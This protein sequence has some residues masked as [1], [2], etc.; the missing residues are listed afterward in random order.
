MRESPET[1]S[2]RETT[3]GVGAGHVRIEFEGRGL[4]EASASVVSRDRQLLS[5]THHLNMRLRI[6]AATLALLGA[7]F[8]TLGAQSSF[9]PGAEAN[10][11]INVQILA[12]LDDGIGGYRE[13][14]R[15]PLRL[16]RP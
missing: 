8:P 14:S 6:I 11:Q 1:R 12:T 9:V 16:P 10:G 3:A 7:A 15:S 13:M 5:P 2:R 4:S